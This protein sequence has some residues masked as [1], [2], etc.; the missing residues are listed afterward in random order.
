MPDVSVS[1]IATFEHTLAQSDKPSAKQAAL[2]ALAYDSAMPIVSGWSRAPH[3]HHVGTSVLYHKVELQDK[4]LYFG[5]TNQHVVDEAFA[6]NVVLP[7]GSMQ[8]I[9]I[10][11]G[12]EDF[13]KRDVAIFTFE[14]D[15][16]LAVAPLADSNGDI[17]GNNHLAGYP[18]KPSVADVRTAAEQVGAKLSFSTH[19]PAVCY[20]GEIE[21]LPRD[22]NPINSIRKKFWRMDSDNSYNLDNLLIIKGMPIYYGMSGAGVINRDGEI[23]GLNFRGS[24]KPVSRFVFEGVALDLRA[25]SDDIKADTQAMIR[26]L[27]SV[28]DR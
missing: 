20:S 1:A 26:E 12:S 10:R 5:L 27:F 16:D 4:K 6:P 24:H 7:D 8:P 25:I 23:V 21:L 13:G 17:R 3:N 19:G 2:S 22:N 11:R 28:S 15:K 9:A 18:R 14:T